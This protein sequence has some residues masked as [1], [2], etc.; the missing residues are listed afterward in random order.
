MLTDEQ[1]K[2][3]QK[4]IDSPYYFF[5]TYWMVNGKPGT[6]IWT[7]EE[8]NDFFKLMET[9]RANNRKRDK[10]DSYL[11]QFYNSIN[12]NETY[13]DSKNQPD[14]APGAEKAGRP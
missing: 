4:C 11:N 2:E 1:S 6:T 8:F 10:V 13:R 9:G 14:D 5:T 12:F 7:E 3:Y